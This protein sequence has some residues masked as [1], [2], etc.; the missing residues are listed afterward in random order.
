MVG[1]QLEGP[2]ALGAAVRFL[3]AA[4]A[5]VD[6]EAL[7]ATFDM[8]LVLTGSDHDGSRTLRDQSEIDDKLVRGLS[9]ASFGM[10]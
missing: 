2:A 8:H 7:P 4:R 3:H 1:L 5:A 9:P 10:I 6:E